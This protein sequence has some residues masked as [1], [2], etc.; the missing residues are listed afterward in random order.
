MEDKWA[1]KF[2]GNWI[3][4]Y[5]YLWNDECIWVFLLSEN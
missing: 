5:I 2:W 3:W 4:S 1:Q